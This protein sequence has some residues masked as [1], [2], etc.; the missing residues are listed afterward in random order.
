MTDNTLLAHRVEGEGEP[1]LLLNGGLMTYAAWEPLSTRLRKH[2]RLI[3]CDLRGQ[4]LSPGLAPRDLAGNVADLTALLDH[5]GLDSVHVLGASYGGEVG[6][7]MAALAPRRVRSLIAV[8]VADY[9]DEAMRV[10]GEEWRRLLAAATDLESRGRF[11]EH[12]VGSVYSD[13]FRRRF[14]N[15]L[16]ARRSQVAAMPDDWWSSLRSIFEAVASLDLRPDLGAIRTPTLI[17]LAASDRLMPAGRSL[18]LAAA[19]AGAETRMH[20]TSGHALVAEDPGW[21]ARVS[22]DFLARHARHGAAAAND[23]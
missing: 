3:L 19:I 23:R 10:D 20:E 5:L 17:V 8:T 16:A 14:G 11:Y 13:A 4:L 22:L 21:L 6:L 2:H 1:L 12:L 9:A 15:E 18:T 7:L